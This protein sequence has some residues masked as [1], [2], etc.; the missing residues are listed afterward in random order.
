MKTLKL[1][2]ESLQK[3][4]GADGQ[5]WFSL[6]DYVIRDIVDTFDLEIPDE[7]NEEEFLRS[8]GYIPYFRINPIDFY[9]SYMST[10]PNNKLR[11][12]MAKVDDKDYIETFW[13]YYRVYPQLS[14]GYEDFQSQ[15]ILE[16]ALQ[17]CGENGIH[18]TIQ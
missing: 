15:Y 13:K 4:W 9:K 16:K 7:M 17:W 12:A 2:E 8:Y 1:D 18:Y 5:Y 3:G 14:D 10:I 11:A 6:E